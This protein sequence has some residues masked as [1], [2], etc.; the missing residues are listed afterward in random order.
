MRRLTKYCIDFFSCV[1]GC[2]SC[3]AQISCDVQNRNFSDLVQI[4]F[5]TCRNYVT[6]N[7]WRHYWYRTCSVWQSITV[8]QL[9]CSQSRDNVL[10]PPH[11][12][13]SLP[14]PR[15]VFCKQTVCPQLKDSDRRLIL[16]HHVDGLRLAKCYYGGLP[17]RK[18]HNVPV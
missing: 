14:L 6:V 1:T 10:Q 15:N 11:A 7:M 9:T 13:V 8:V 17:K 2:T 5:K 4:Y 18:E 12:L 16:Q 3:Y